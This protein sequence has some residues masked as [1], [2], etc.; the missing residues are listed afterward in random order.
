MIVGIKGQ[1]PRPAGRLS[2][3]LGLDA[4]P[5]RR[6]S[7]R[8]ESWIRLGLLAAFLLTGPFTAM[9]AGHWME[10]AGLREARTQAADERQVHATLLR[11]EPAGR[12]LALHEVS[13]LAW[14][15]ARWT[16]PGG[17]PRTGAVAAVLPVRAG[18][19]VTIWTT[20]TGQLARPPLLRS[21]ITGRATVLVVLTPAIMA[22]VL[23][24]I[25][26]MTRRIL[27]RRRLAGWATAWSAIGPQW[28]SRY[29]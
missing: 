29:R 9:A 24:G 2:R 20:A 5:L 28:S 22:L 13:V 15:P 25:L 8:A 4:N 10:H 14:V 1:R 21:Q 17:S 19:T 26:R 6:A 16:A 12:T 27:D 23:L 7:D 18:S 11:D 3:R